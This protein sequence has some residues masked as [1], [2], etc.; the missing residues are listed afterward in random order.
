[1]VKLGL[2]VLT[3]LL[4]LMASTASAQ[5][6]GG[7]GPKDKKNS[8]VTL[9]QAIMVPQSVQGLLTQTGNGC[10]RAVYGASMAGGGGKRVVT[11]GTLT[12]IGKGKLTK[13]AKFNYSPEPK[14]RLRIVFSNGLATEFFIQAIQQVAN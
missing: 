11:T 10:L 12:Q 3:S 14:D 6:L 2:K 7:L 5:D 13:E 4:I 8:K 9:K 1:M